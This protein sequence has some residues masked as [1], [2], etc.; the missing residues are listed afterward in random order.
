MRESKEKQYRNL[1]RLV[2]YLFR[3]VGWDDLQKTTIKDCKTQITVINAAGT[4]PQCVA[5]IST[6]M[7]FCNGC[8][9]KLFVAEQPV[10]EHSS[11][12]S[13]GSQYLLTMET[14]NMK[15]KTVGNAC[16]KC[17]GTIDSSTLI[18]SVCGETVLAQAVSPIDEKKPPGI[19]G[20]LFS[21]LFSLLLAVSTTLLVLLLFINALNKNVQIPSMGPISS[22]WLAVFFD[23]WYSLILGGVLVLLPMLIIIFINT[24]R[25]RR[26]FVSIGISAIISALF[27]A[28]LGFGDT[29]VIKLLSGE[30]QDTLINTTAVFKD[31]TFIC[32]VIL[33]VIGATCL[34]VY[35][36]ITVIKG[37]KHEKIT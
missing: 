30:W 27:S 36:C 37:A 17:G 6:G 26:V 11:A 29:R 8:S 31:F 9:H 19:F 25:I 12:C 7:A 3:I 33:I 20:A 5:I 4:C 35:S 14:C 32:A 34:S 15:K 16:P 2:L 13:T 18:C 1:R 28:V 24:H 10:A 21:G 23:S 22:D